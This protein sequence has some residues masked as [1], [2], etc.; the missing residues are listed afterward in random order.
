MNA[1]VIFCG[2]IL[3]L[4][5][6]SLRADT[7]PAPITDP[8]AV[9]AHYHQ[10]LAQPQYQETDESPIDTRFEDW[11]S[12][13]FK[14]LGAR[15]GEFKY[16]T[17]MPAFESLLMT[18][19]VFFSL[20]GLLYIMARVTRR[21]SGME[22]EPAADSPGAK[23]FRSPE[24]YDHE[25][26]HALRAGDWHCAWLAA[27]R[28]FL[29]RLEHRHLVEPDRTRTNREYLAQLRERALPGATLTLVTGMVETYDRFIYGRKPISEP[30]WQRFHGQ[31]DEAALL[32]NLNV[33]KPQLSPGA[34]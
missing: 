25:I 4:G 23:A 16:A 12:Q 28:Q 27:W 31:L 2:F 29:S 19:L 20:A 26:N 7:A 5:T 32:L 10:V 14:S 24:F 1:R 34:P 6:N 33:K 30:D 17:Q 13:W 9:R 22:P 18:I 21:R 11:L 3:L 15:F 8:V